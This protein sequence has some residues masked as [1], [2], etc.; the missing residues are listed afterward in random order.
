MISKNLGWALLA[1]PMLLFQARAAERITKETLESQ[2]KKRTY[3]LMIPDSAKSPA[4]VP[5][6]VL[7]HGSGPLVST[8]LLLPAKWENP[9]QAG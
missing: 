6:I 4:S 2:G 5:L 8:Q 1:L 9:R 7:L 3:Y